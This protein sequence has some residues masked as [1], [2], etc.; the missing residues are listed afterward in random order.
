MRSEH[1]RLKVAGVAGLVIAGLVVAGGL[2]TRQSRA[3]QL[4]DRAA[5]AVVPT[6]ALVSPSK[7]GGGGLELPARLE[8]WSRAPIYARASGYLKRWS[9]DIGAPVKAGQVMAE[10]EAPDLQQQL[11][12]AK[13]EAATAKANAELSALTAKRWKS[14]LESNS[15][16]RQ[17]VDDR[18]GDATA[19]QSTANAAK[20]NVD[21]LESL[22]GYLKVTAPF[23]GVVTARNT[24][25]GAL[26]NIGGAAGSELFVVSDMRKLRV[27]VNVPQRQVPQVRVGVKARLA[28]PERPGQFYTATVASLAQSI[29]SGSGTMQVQLSVDNSKGELLPGGFATLR[30]DSL[31][32]EGLAVPPGAV[33]TGKAGVRVA[34]VDASNHVR[35]KP[36]TISRDLGNVVELEG[37][38]AQD[39]IIDSPP[40]GLAEGDEVRVMAAPAAKKKAG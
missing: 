30:F 34:T 19:K 10:I 22:A 40:D 37:L 21:R 32:A 13:A 20:A 27:Y 3:A 39:R 11:A 16:S 1:S 14:L 31:A 28:V 7:T 35:L 38:T 23:D 29:A 5:D 15:V 2:W 12:Q 24:D 18:V 9:V 26:I 17:D 36:V 33:I 6:V 25:V 4:K 8:A